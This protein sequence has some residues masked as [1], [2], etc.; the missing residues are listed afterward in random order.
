MEFPTFSLV[1]S[2]LQFFGDEKHKEHI[3]HLNFTV[4]HTGNFN[5]C[6]QLEKYKIINLD[7][8]RV[9]FGTFFVDAI[10]N[11]YIKSEMEDE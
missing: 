3:R 11:I 7:V 8:L 10:V 6:F 2:V 4:W 1:S 5:H 9:A